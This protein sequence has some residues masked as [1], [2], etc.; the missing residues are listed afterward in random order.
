MKR[1]KNSTGNLLNQFDK[2]LRAIIL[3]DLKLFKSNNGRFL[4]NNPGK[5]QE[6]DLQVA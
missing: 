1:T 5:R 2:E 6:I 4:R 3:Y